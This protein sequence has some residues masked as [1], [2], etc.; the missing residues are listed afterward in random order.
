MIV[1]EGRNIYIF[2]DV[3]RTAVSYLNI[4]GERK[5]WAGNYE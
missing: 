5:N 1:F 2:I 4:R 3:A